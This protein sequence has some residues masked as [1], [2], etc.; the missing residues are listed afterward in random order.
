MSPFGNTCPMC[1]GDLDKT[2][3][4]LC[5]SCGCNTEASASAARH[6]DPP[7]SGAITG[8]SHAQDIQMQTRA[9]AALTELTTG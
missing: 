8:V 9:G 4:A 3:A 5:P 1:C 6:P 7:A 2:D